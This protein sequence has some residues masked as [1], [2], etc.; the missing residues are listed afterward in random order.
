MDEQTDSVYIKSE[1]VFVPVSTN[2]REEQMRRLFDPT[3]YLNVVENYQEKI[4]SSSNPGWKFYPN[5]EGQTQVTLENTMQLID[6]IV[7]Y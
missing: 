7:K 4:N 2:T 1:D 5:I 3:F 6:S